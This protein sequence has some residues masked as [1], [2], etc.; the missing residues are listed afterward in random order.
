LWKCGTELV[1][2]RG[3]EGIV[4]WN[5]WGRS[6]GCE[7]RGMR[8]V[9]DVRRGRVRE[10]REVG[11]GGEGLAGPPTIPGIEKGDTIMKGVK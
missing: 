2:E 4:N 3:M 7:W 8:N 9:K 11:D 1:A 5:E 10:K 6:Y